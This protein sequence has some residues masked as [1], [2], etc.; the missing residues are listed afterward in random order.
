MDVFH[1]SG[2]VPIFDGL[3]L[4]VVHGDS[5]SSLDDESEVLAAFGIELAF[6]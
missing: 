1:G 3:D 2:D 5:L 4:F 6:L